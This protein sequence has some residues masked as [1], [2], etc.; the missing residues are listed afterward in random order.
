MSGGSYDY[1][2]QHIK[3]LADE[4]NTCP[5]KPGYDGKNP[6]LNAWR[7]KFKKILYLVAEAARAI[8]W[9]DSCDSG[10]GDDHSAIDAVFNEAKRTK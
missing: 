4:I 5:A 6:P 2:Y 3:D 10:Y 1:K 7:V 8:E 9:V